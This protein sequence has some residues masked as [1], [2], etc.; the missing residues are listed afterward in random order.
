[1]GGLILTILLLPPDEVE[2]KSGGRLSGKIVSED[3]R[4]VQLKTSAGALI[5]LD[6]AEIDRI[7]YKETPDE[8]FARRLSAL[9]AGDTAGEL[10]LA[11]W[12]VRQK[13]E[14]RAV[15]L[16]REILERDPACAEA[17]RRLVPL[18]APEAER[19]FKQARDHPRASEGEAMLRRLLMEFPECPAT[20]PARILLG[21]RAL[22]AGRPDEAAALFRAA[23]GPEAARGLVG[24]AIQREA[25]DEIPPLLDA[26]E[27]S[28]RAHARRLLEI[29]PGERVLASL[30]FD[31][32]DIP[33]ALALLRAAGASRDLEALERRVRYGGEEVD[34]DLER[35]TAAALQ[36]EPY[37]RALLDRVPRR[38]LEAAVRRSRR[39]DPEPAAGRLLTKSAPL[40]AGGAIE[41]IVRPPRG[42]DPLFAY[43]LLVSLHGRHGR[44][45]IDV[46]L[47]KK[48]IE[49]REGIVLACPTAGPA[50]WGSSLAGHDNVLAVVEDVC[51]VYSIDADRI[52]FSGASMGGGGSLEVGCHYPG[53]AAAVSPR[54]GCFRIRISGD[55]R[56][57]LYAENLKNTPVYWIAGAKDALVPIDSVRIGV[58]R[59]RELGADL[60]YREYANRGHEWYPEEDEPVLDWMLARSRPR[61]PAEVEIFSDEARLRRSWWVEILE[62]AGKEAGMMPHVGQD[63]KVMEERPL[64]NPPARIDARVHPGK[65]QITL[66]VRGVTRL[67][68]TLHDSM[69]ALDRPV[70]VMVNGRAQIHRDLK[71][72]AAFLLDEARRT[73]DRSRLYWTHIE[74]AVKP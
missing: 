33:Q 37:D 36:G 34:S 44:G 22:Q 38:L 53:L 20:G 16:Y 15:A 43:P 70:T 30:A 25:W 58:S 64:L 21:R 32:I 42:Y 41:Y 28:D 56:T 57:A 52:Y 51:R 35:E 61:Y 9:T 74:I 26:L 3:P 31:A 69:V 17:R 46:A 18:V 55:A 19:L 50:G 4:R 27:A 59:L 14:A 24:A 7:V 5:T 49:D 1:M 72:S 13:L 73:G 2:L 6:R 67:R 65:N 11:D 68:L 12:A 8:E 10:A 54:V 62:H 39:F 63:A 23:S 47:W 66:S 48:E 71:P 45:E 40:K 60:V 29:P